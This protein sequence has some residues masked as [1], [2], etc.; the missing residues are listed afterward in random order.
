MVKKAAEAAGN[1]S[2]PLLGRQPA[3]ERAPDGGYKDNPRFVE[4]DPVFQSLRGDPE[5][6]RMIAR[7]RADQ[8]EMARRVLEQESN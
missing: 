3:R 6:E 8:E 5:S 2:L 1:R 4:L 7:I